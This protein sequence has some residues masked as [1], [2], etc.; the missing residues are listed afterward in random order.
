[1]TALRLRAVLQPAPLF[2]DRQSLGDAVGE[3][4]AGRPALVRRNGAVLLLSPQDAVG[5]HLSRRLIDLPLVA[6]ALVAPETPVDEALEASPQA[7]YLVSE[8][9]SGEMALVSRV[10]LVE[11]LMRDEGLGKR[12]RGAGALLHVFEH[13][14]EGIVILGERSQVAAL[15][16]MGTRILSALGAPT[17]GRL[18][19]LAGIPLDVLMAESSQGIPRDLVTPEPGAQ[20]YTVRTLRPSGDGEQSVILILREVTHL[21]HH[22]A[23]EAEQ[24]R[25]ALLGYLATG[26]VHDINNLLTVVLG[27][28]SLL[29][30]GAAGR[31]AVQPSARIIETAAYR[32]A[33]MLRQI[34]AF[35]KRELAS[36]VPLRLNEAIR[37][38]EPLLRRIAGRRV[39]LDTPFPALVRPILADPI[40]IERI[41]TNLVANASEAMPSGGTLR[42][43]LADE[44]E[45]PWLPR[46]PEG[47]LVPGVR[48]TVADDG[49]GM[50]PQTAARAFEPRFTTK[51][52]KGTGMGLATVHAT[53]TQMGGH[54]RLTTRPGGG[55]RFDLHFPVCPEVIAARSMS[56]ARAE[57][58]PRARHSGRL[59]V[60]ETEPEVADF[61][62]RALAH[63]GYD[64]HLSRSVPAAL[65]LVRLHGE[66]DLAILDARACEDDRQ[67][68]GTL[69]RDH[70]QLRVLLIG[71]VASDTI[72]Q[73]VEHPLVESLAK[74]FT[75]RTLVDRVEAIVGPAGAAPQE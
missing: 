39:S 50:D 48:L 63:S 35:A 74:P 10:A 7:E 65:E 3:L 1:M 67:F 61:V 58:T 43:E 30:T 15:N 55:A 46:S 34:L 20:V 60:M 33:S 18:D 14:P 22:Q 24:E 25:M 9:S 37:E 71:G 68:L 69:R 56:L 51:G 17:T 70:P 66:P 42:V 2:N 54:I 53:V 49:V 52:S 72:H 44:D 19:Q 41:L 40:Q 13:S 5:H 47:S 26:I 31:D 75:A 27:E 36:P 32:A 8:L 38:S 28:A 73:E 59:L 21:R 6:A 29:D 57:E 12:R 45:C 4:S 62:S 64:H 11:A 23:K 16:P